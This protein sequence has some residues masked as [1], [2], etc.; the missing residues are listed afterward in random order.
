MSP[1][2]DAKIVEHAPSDPIVEVLKGAVLARLLHHPDRAF[3]FEVTLDLARGASFFGRRPPTH[4]HV[5]EEYI[6][7]TRGRVGLELEG[8]EIVLTSG[9]DARFDIPPYAHHRSYPLPPE[10][11]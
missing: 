5:Q 7:A 11:Q 9:P 3:A 8:R 1:P 6:E 2:S 10:R 4:F